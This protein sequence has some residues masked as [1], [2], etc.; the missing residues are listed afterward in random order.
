MNAKGLD[1]FR[2]WSFRRPVGH[3]KSR[4]VRAGDAPM[5]EQ[6]AYAPIVDGVVMTS[7]A[8]TGPGFD[9]RDAAEWHALASTALAKA[10]A[11]H[12]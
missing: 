3:S 6:W 4:A 5:V 9:T 1:A 12:V 10:G 8:V 2:F 7:A 11:D